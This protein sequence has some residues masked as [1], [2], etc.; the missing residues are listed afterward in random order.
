MSA[1]DLLARL[2][3]RGWTLAVAESLTGGLVAARITSVPGASTVFR[4]AVVAYATE[5]KRQVLGVPGA[6]LEEHG[7]VSASTA[8]GMAEGARRVLGADVGIATTGVA[9]PSRQDGV[10]VGVVF[11]GV[12]LPGCEPSARELFLDGDRGRIR[13]RAVDAALAFAEALVGNTA[14]PAGV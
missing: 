1:A 10:A 6:V 13:D 7:P 9:G 12:A 3:E 11:V 2:R 4:G 5:V 8:V 14:G